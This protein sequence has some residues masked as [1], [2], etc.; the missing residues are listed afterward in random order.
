MGF[1]VYNTLPP[2]RKDLTHNIKKFKSSL[3][4][5]LHPINFIQW[6]NISIIKQFLTTQLIFI[7]L[8]LV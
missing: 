5:F 7:I 8:S 4:R 6:T 3:R 2:E 1:K